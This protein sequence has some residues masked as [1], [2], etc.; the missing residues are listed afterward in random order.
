MGSAAEI[1][2][3]ERWCH[4]A[5]VLAKGFVLALE[6]EQIR[7]STLD[8]IHEM[9]RRDGTASQRR[10]LDR[11]ASSHQEVKRLD[12][13]LLERF[14]DLSDNGPR[15]QI[16]AALS[17]VLMNVSPVL[18]IQIPFGGDNHADEGFV[19]ERDETISGI[20]TLNY[21]FQS[22]DA[23]GLRDRVVVANLHVF[24]RTFRQESRGGR[25]H[26]LN[27]HVMMLSGSNVN[28]G[29]VGSLMPSGNDFG[30][31]AIDSVTGEGREG[32]DIPVDQ[33]LESA[34]KTLGSVLGMPSDRLDVRISGGKVIQSVLRG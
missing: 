24:G 18:R 2:V 20:E 25:Q 33:T 4:R 6:L 27:H 14:N 19:Q 30:A 5:E 10:M 15:A 8:S 22:I 17:L 13:T 31:S 34:A 11:Y 26:N 21:L 3:I 16:D 9:L 23:L 28:P 32:A 1:P 7:E 29:V 12:E